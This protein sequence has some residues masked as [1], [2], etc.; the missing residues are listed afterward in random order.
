[1]ADKYHVVIKEKIK[2][3]FILLLIALFILVARLV[4]I[5]LLQS[6]YYKNM[7][8]NQRVKNLSIE[9][10]RGN[11]YDLNGKELA[12]NTKSKTVI[13]FPDQ[14]EDPAHIASL[15]AGIL[16]IDEAKIKSRLERDSYLVY[17][18]RKVSDEIYQEIEEMNIS[19]ISY[20]QEDERL[21]PQDNLAGQII[22]FTGI[23][24]FGLEGI[25]LSY[26]N[27]LEGIP[28]RS[29][30]EYDASGRTIPDGIMDYIPPQEGNDIFLTIDEV[31]Q[32]YAEKE[33]EEAMGKHDISG[34]SIIVMN[35]EDGSI[36]ALANKPDFN[37]NDFS[38]Y[39]LNTRRNKAIQNSFEP[40]SIFKI[41]T[42]ALALE[43][44]YYDMN[45]YF[46]DP[47]H[48]N[49]GREEISSWRRGGHGWQDFSDIFANSSNPG[50]VQM[51]LNIDSEEY[52]TG[53]R[54][55]NFGSKTG[56]NFPG[57]STGSLVPGQYTEIEQATMSFGHGL[58]AT[59]LQLATAVASIA[60]GGYLYEPRLVDRVYNYEKAEEKKLESHKIR[61]VLSE[62]TAEKVK[63]L[64]INAVQTGTGSSAGI[65]GYLVGGKTGTSRHYGEEDIYDTSFVG[66]LPGDEPE[67][68]IYVVFYDL[69]DEDYYA[70]ENVVPT[71]NSL[72]SNLVRHLDISIS[73]RSYSEENTPEETI[74]INDYS[75]KD[76]NLIESE[77]R[78]RNLNVKL[79]GKGEKII[80]QTPL[81]GTKIS[82]SSTVRLYLDNNSYKSKKAAVPDLE[83]LSAH[84]AEQRAWRFG[85]KLNGMIS[86]T[87]KDQDPS[88][89]ERIDIFSAIDIE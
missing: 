81:P 8:M 59:P 64:M 84:E 74:T 52:L 53:L 10:N 73:N 45:D 7:A 5:Q 34:G 9:T 65:D 38:E 48:I 44:G 86:G 49:V 66:L 2:V 72:A 50:F 41:F 82:E 87:V 1:M 40:G 54:S 71:F 76:V 14:I 62:N 55:F 30:K 36:L 68:L 63:N 75:D 60:N 28:G 23:D 42:A 83:G 89:G 22:G 70:S 80:A 61:Q 43:Y 6:D 85:F 47:G 18:E 13:A 32:Y 31:S 88:P 79:I 24:N 3:I 77:L 16:S 25:E 57:E 37:P 21:Y 27:E 58:T 17:I 15:L 56:I 4:W 29:L 78:N 11:I 35:P 12:V 51:G 39:N 46:S 19:G 33:L 69:K 67:L 20:I 26:N